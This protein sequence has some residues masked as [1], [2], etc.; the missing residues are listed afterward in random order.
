MTIPLIGI[1]ISTI[2]LL[3]CLDHWVRA[4][5]RNRISQPPPIKVFSP[6]EIAFA[7]HVLHVRE[8]RR[9]ARRSA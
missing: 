2:C 7:Q 9:R 1:F 3:T 6:A 5:W 8:Q 4:W